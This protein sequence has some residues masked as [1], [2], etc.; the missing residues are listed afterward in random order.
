MSGEGGRIVG[1]A[2]DKGAAV[3]GDVVD[4]IGNGDADGIIAEVVIKDAAR[5]T[6]PAPTGVFEAAY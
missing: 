2:D 5:I 1:N 6:F 4:A 3:F